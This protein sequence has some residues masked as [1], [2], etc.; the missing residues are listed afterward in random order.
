MRWTGPTA[1]RT[2]PEHPQP[3]QAEAVSSAV[4]K[5]TTRHLNASDST[6]DTRFLRYA[7]PDPRLEFQPVY[8]DRSYLPPSVTC[9]WPSGPQ[10]VLMDLTPAV[11]GLVGFGVGLMGLLVCAIAPALAVI[12]PRMNRGELLVR[13]PTQGSRVKRFLSLWR[14]GA[15]EMKQL[16][17]LRAVTGGARTNEVIMRLT[18]RSS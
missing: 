12:A 4:P 13:R 15:H 18:T 6:T 2:C 10:F 17:A 11:F 1:S 9:R 5:C 7:G 8:L 3:G 16:T 14:R